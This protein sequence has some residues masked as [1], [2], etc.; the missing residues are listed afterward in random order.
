MFGE[1][2]NE[3]GKVRLVYTGVEFATTEI[4]NAN[5]VNTEHTWPQSKFKNATGSHKGKMKADLHLSRNSDRPDR[6]DRGG[7]TGAEDVGRGARVRVPGI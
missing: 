4:P 6:E 2:D 5:V 1:V 7:V 3:N